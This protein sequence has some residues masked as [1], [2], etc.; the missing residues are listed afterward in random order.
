MITDT[1]TIQGRWAYALTWLR[2]P[3]P[4]RGAERRSKQV[5]CID[6]IREALHHVNSLVQLEHAYA[7]DSDWCMALMCQL[8]PAEAHGLGRRMVMAAAYGLRQVELCTGRRVMAR[9]LPKW[10]TEWTD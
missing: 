4:V 3:A 7:T 5:I 2:E 10:I 8:Y 6:T 1:E 9:A